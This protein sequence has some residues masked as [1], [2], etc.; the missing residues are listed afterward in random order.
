MAD[1]SLFSKRFGSS[2]SVRESWSKREKKSHPLFRSR[3]N[4]LDKLARKRFLRNT[5]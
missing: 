3:P 4:L 1:N 2:Y 5:G